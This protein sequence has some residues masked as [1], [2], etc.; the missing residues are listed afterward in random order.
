MSCDFAA[1]Y[2]LR[3]RFLSPMPQF[4]AACMRRSDGVRWLL[5]A[6]VALAS[7]FAPAMALEA[8]P[9]QG[10]PSLAEL[11]RA[12]AK[13]GEIRVDTLNIFDVDDPAENNALFRLANRLHI[14]TD[15]SVIRRALPF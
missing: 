11:E 13:I 15:R 8:S 9:A 12:G 4:P 3:Q 5:A 6:W 7:A 10:V 1:F 2:L 14:R